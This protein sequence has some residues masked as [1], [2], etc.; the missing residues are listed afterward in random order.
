MAPGREGLSAIGERE[1]EETIVVT[2][3]ICVVYNFEKSG[4]S[5]VIYAETVIYL[6]QK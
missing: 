6:F 2:N 5:K 3:V 1:T 4:L